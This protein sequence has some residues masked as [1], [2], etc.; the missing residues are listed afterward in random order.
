MASVSSKSFLSLCEARR[1]TLAG[2]NATSV[3]TQQLIIL[4]ESQR[5]SAIA[6]SATQGGD[7]D[8]ALFD[9]LDGFIVDLGTNENIEFG[10]VNIT[11]M[12]SPT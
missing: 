3:D 2:A 8:P 5:A 6:L 10:N 4:T 9:G 1:F 11:A 12:R 7:G